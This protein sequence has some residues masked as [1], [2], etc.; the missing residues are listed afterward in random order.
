[1]TT[2]ATLSLPP[3]TQV[4]PGVATV[5]AWC[6]AA[7]L[8]AP[9]FGACCTAFTDSGQLLSDGF[10]GQSVVHDF[11]GDGDLDTFL[12]YGDAPSVWLNDGTGTFS[13]HQTFGNGFNV[14]VGDLDDDGD[15]DLITVRIGFGD[16]I[17]FNDGSANFT[18]G[19]HF[20]RSSQGGVVV[21]FGDIDGDGD[22]DL[23]STGVGVPVAIWLNDGSGNFT[24][25]GVSL[26]AGDNFD[27]YTNMIALADVD[28]DDDLDLLCVN[29]WAGRQS[30]IYL[31]DGSGSFTLSPHGFGT[32]VGISLLVEDFD[33]DGDLDIFNGIKGQS[34]FWLNDG[35][36]VFT[37]TGQR[38][39]NA[40]PTSMAAGD[41]DFDGDL[42]VLI[43]FRSG[44]DRLYCNDGAGNFTD[45]GI[46]IGPSASSYLSV[47][48]LDGDFDL[49]IVRA[50]GDG[51]PGPATVQFN[52]VDPDI[53]L[54]DDG[55]I[56]PVDN[57]IDIFNPTQVD[58]DGDGIGDPCDP[59]GP[60][61]MDCA[62]GEDEDGDADV[63][64]ADTDCARA[65]D[66]ADEDADEDGVVNADDNCLV[67]PNPRQLDV[68]A[69]GVG[70]AC[71]L[72]LVFFAE[73]GAGLELGSA[74]FFV[75][76]PNTVRFTGAGS[77]ADTN[78]WDC[79]G[80]APGALG[81]GVQCDGS[82]EEP[83]TGTSIEFA[84]FSFEVL[85]TD[86]VDCDDFGFSPD[87][88]NEFLD[89]DLGFVTP[90]SITCELP[91]C[92]PADIH[93]DG[94]GDGLVTLADYVVGRR[95]VLGIIA[96]NDRDAACADLHPGEV[97]CE[98]APGV[99]YWCPT[100]DGSF[101]FGDSL[102]MR[103]IVLRQYQLSCETCG[104]LASF[105]GP[106]TFVPGD[107]APLG[108]RNGV[109]D[110]ADVVLALRFAVGLEEAG[111]D[112][113][114]QLDVAPT[115]TRRGELLARGDGELR[116][117]DVVAILRA[118]VGLAPIAWPEHEL[119]VV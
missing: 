83:A 50:V 115:E 69:D 41:F 79:L 110:I 87:L 45:A 103:R 61:E 58:R 39:N 37:D 18:A 98:E 71:D 5:V 49:D 113:L 68:D 72:T 46:T 59:D 17:W 75:D 57:C 27:N 91:E 21:A 30:L 118:A 95:K 16:Q 92:I 4:R 60:A 1:M 73:D 90:E 3:P 66:C 23:L 53:D 56:D 29:S 44:L 6:L 19:Q 76:A 80:D 13:H 43:A 9:S 70:D 97:T 104:G 101:D 40:E 116:I 33:D 88:P 34:E 109:V 111:A 22:L 77:G 81:P 63:D 28:G 78:D 94:V 31:N 14:A 35:T 36:G 11:D 106:T 32:L 112:E 108:F 51:A 38:F 55:V 100:G 119:V 7:L 64:C 25:S 86:V 47:G 26:S 93:P 65:E 67:V 42:D 10:S 2:Q 12:A 8:L 52:G 74:L 105:G 15:L 89:G 54:D 117:D 82:G 102:V 24:D 62:D 84:R 48:D 99:S 107:A 20:P 96:P 114:W 85:T